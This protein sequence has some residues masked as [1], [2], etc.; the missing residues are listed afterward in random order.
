MAAHAYC[1]TCVL[2]AGMDNCGGGNVLAVVTVF[3]LGI[4]LCLFFF[5][6]WNVCSLHSNESY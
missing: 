3:G 5:W 1:S 2:A 4:E 6:I